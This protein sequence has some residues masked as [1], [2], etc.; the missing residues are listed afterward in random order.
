[1]LISHQDEILL[2][3]LWLWLPFNWIKRPNDFKADM[4]LITSFLPEAV[5]TICLLNVFWSVRS[6]WLVM[7][8][9]KINLSR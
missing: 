1:M 3:N 8:Q 2:T 4:V 7:K 6:S 9:S 5:V